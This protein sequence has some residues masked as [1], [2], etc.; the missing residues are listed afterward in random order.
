[1]VR[2]MNENKIKKIPN[3]KFCKKCIYD[4]NIPGISFDKNGICNY[5]KMIEELKLKYGTENEKG[6]KILNDIITK[7]KKKKEK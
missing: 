4:E 1:M 2:I 6:E 7:I 5:C 3:I